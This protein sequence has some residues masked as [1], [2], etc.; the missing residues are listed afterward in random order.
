MAPRVNAFVEAL[1]A[2]PELSQL[3][4]LAFYCIVLLDEFRKTSSLPSDPLAAL[5]TIVDRMLSREGD[6]QVFAWRDFVDLDVLDDAALVDEAFPSAQL[7]D[8]PKGMAAIEQVLDK[9][10]RENLREMLGLIAHQRVRQATATGVEIAELRDA[11]GPVYIDSSLASNETDRVL[12]S[13]VQFAFFGAG[14]RA[15]AVDFSH[16]ILA[17]HLAA[18]YALG[19]LG[20]A[21]KRVVD[22]QHASALSRAT[23]IKGAVR[24]ALGPAKLDP[25]T[26]FF[27]ALRRG[28]GREPDVVALLQAA[29]GVLNKSERK[30]A[31][32][33][34]LLVTR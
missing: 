7:T 20:A 29:Q 30:L 32:Q 8:G 10:G 1:T 5:D 24:Q 12:T 33:I 6:K 28:V 21:A 14:K 15:G 16:P 13:V 23:M 19:L 17:D 27:R 26:V 3:A 25:D 34:E 9:T 31:D 11:V 4:S 22:M 2:S 18:S